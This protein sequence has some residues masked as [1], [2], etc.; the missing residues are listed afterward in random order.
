MKVK[1]FAIHL[2][3]IVISFGIKYYH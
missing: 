2:F 1:L 3:F